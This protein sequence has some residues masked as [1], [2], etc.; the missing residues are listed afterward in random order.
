MHMN[1]E[2][3]AKTFRFS[4]GRIVL[5]GKVNRFQQRFNPQDWE[6]NPYDLSNK[7]SPWPIKDHSMVANLNLLL[8]WFRI[9]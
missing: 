3:S 8:R 6:A 9:M 5:L 7:T 2:V 4:N 1:V